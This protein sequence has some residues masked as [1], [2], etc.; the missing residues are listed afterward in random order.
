MEKIREG[1]KR[2]LSA[3]NGYMVFLLLSADVC[4]YTCGQLTPVTLSRIKKHCTCI[5]GYITDLQPFTVWG[6]TSRCSYSTIVGND[7]RRLPPALF[8]PN[9]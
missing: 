2:G 4:V 3:A 6:L 1:E 7:L 8:L 9:S 5:K